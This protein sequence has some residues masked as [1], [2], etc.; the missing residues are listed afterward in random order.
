MKGTVV[1]DGVVTCPHCGS[2]SFESARTKKVKL[3]F[4]V[5]SLLAS[6]KLRCN[7]CG[8]FLDPKKAAPQKSA[9]VKRAPRGMGRCEKNGHL[10]DAKRDV[11]PIDGSPI[12]PDRKVF[13]DAKPYV[14]GGG[15]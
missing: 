5:A 2:Q 14:Q 9:P 10:V 12:L 13:E 3:A 11:C 15:Q 4:G 6:P 7:G 1:K 8:R